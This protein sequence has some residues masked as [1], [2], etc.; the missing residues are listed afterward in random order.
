M[1]NLGFGKNIQKG[2]QIGWKRF[3]FRRLRNICNGK[4]AMIRYFFVIL[5]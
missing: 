2:L 3:T 4:F 5:L 1:R